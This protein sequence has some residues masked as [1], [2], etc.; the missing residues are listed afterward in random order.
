MIKTLSIFLAFQVLLSSLSF[1]IGMHFCGDSLK[2]F[3]LF[4]KAKPCEHSAMADGHKGMKDCP[5][6]S[7]EKKSDK[8]DCCNDKEVKVE[9]QDIDT[10]ISSFSFDLSPHFEFIAAYALSLRNLFQ[11]ET[12]SSKYLSY[13][14]PLIQVDI[15]LLIQ[16]FLI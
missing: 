1:N 13:K 7:Q 9:G 11:E 10:T 5:F 14:P 3:S 8:D 2:S 4:D 15:P 6:H 12:Y 16:T